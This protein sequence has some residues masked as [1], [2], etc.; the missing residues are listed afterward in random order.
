MLPSLGGQ[1]EERSL[2]QMRMLLA[3][4]DPGDKLS[5]GTVYESLMNHRKE[6]R[7]SSLVEAEQI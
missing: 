2:G 4:L 3:V 7:R 5:F 6:G 1:E